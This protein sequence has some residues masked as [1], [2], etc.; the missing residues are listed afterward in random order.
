MQ[1]HVH[2]KRSRFSVFKTP[3]N[4]LPYNIICMVIKLCFNV[5]KLCFNVKIPAKMYV[6]STS[7]YNIGSMAIQPITDVLYI[8][9][10]KS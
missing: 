2:N 7:Y 6:L 3:Y 9:V 10:P 4:Y 5:E 1:G 8:S